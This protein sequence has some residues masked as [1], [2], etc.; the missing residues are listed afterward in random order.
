MVPGPARA[1]NPFYNVPSAYRLSGPLDVGALERALHQVVARHEALRTRFPAPG[2]R[3]SQHVDPPPTVTIAVEDLSQA[4]AG[5]AE[6]RARA[7]AATEAAAPFDLARG[8]LF[9]TRLLRL[10]PDEH[11]LLLT[12]H[13]I[14]AD[15]WSTGVLLAALAAGYRACSSP[16][17]LDP[18]SGRAPDLPVQ[19]AD[20][21]VWQ[22]RWLAGGRLE[23][24]LG[25]WKARLAGLPAFE[26]P[27]DHPR[28]PMPSY[29]GAAATFVVPAS[30]AR[31]LRALGRSQGATL[32]M[33]L[34][35]GFT[36]LLARA[37]GRTD[38]VVGGT[39]AGRTHRELED[40]IGFFVNPLV[41]RTDLSGDPPFTEVL[42]RVRQTALEAYQHQDAPFEKVVERIAP[43]R[44]LSR[45]PL[46]QIAFELHEH[47]PAPA[48]LGDGVALTDVGGCT[49][50]AYGSPDGVGLPARLDLELFVVESS[51]GSL[52]ASL[53][54]AV[55]LYDRGTMVDLTRSYQSLLRAV[56]DDA[57][58]RLSQLPP[59]LPLS[60]ARAGAGT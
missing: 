6:A 45:S 13:H 17:P 32:H 33:T 47:A 18:G 26:L 10:G 16:A 4:G 20:Y 30:V 55:E 51:A 39:T 59:L 58:L 2:G 49:G 27:P 57:S 37:T 56:V 42:A 46:V 12:L 54:W 60:S 29:R 15:A 21:A 25:Y 31:P 23:A 19:Y 48:T 1:G 8:P 34:L 14:V 38:V 52:D 3:P 50:A 36:A 53:V 5:Q 24:Q 9:R 43:R 44:D 35:A 40:L 11:V 41:L 7:I 28:P 22:R